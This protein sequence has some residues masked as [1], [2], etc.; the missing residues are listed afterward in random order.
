MNQ[1]TNRPAGSQIVRARQRPAGVKPPAHWQSSAAP[2]P[3][4]PDIAPAEDQPGGR[5]PV[6]YGD[7][8]YKGL[9]IDF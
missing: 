8:E 5:N 1:S 7:W 4:E 3:R 9:A 2:N 6:R